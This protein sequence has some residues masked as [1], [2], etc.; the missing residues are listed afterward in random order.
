MMRWSYRSTSKNGHELPSGRPG[1]H[2]LQLRLHRGIAQAP[3]VQLMAMTGATA[4][5]RGR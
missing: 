2:A 1:A 5:A 3:D 4:L